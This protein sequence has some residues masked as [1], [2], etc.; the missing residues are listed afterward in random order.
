MLQEGRG[1]VG[2]VEGQVSMMDVSLET[3]L[4]KAP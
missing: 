4:Q 1:L 2:G 3:Y